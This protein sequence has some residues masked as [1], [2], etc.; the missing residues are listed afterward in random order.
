LQSIE[1]QNAFPLNKGEIVISCLIFKKWALSEKGSEFEE[2]LRDLDKTQVRIVV[3]LE[4]RKFRK[5]V[6]IVLGLPK[7]K[8]DLE[9]IARNLKRKLATGGTAKEGTILLQ[10]DHREDIREELIKLGYPSSQ[11]EVQ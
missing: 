4:T 6:T 10:G 5:P 1:V 7:A 9:E 11:I 3:R 8:H 2:V